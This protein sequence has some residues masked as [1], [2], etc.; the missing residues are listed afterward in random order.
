VVAALLTVTVLVRGRGR[1]AIALAALTP[2]AFLLTNRV[3]SPQ[4][5]VVILVAWAIAAALVLETRREQLL[6]GLLAMGATTANAFVYPYT[7]FEHN[8][9]RA[10]SA[11]LFAVGLAT[12]AWLAWQAAAY[13]TRAQSGL[14]E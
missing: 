2:A 5:L 7:L 12:T 14:A 4:Y 3:F 8:L 10:S 11:A 6:L 13:G 1:A 9:W